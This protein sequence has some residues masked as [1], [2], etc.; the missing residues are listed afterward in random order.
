MKYE[1]TVFVTEPTRLTERGSQSY[2]K[3]MPD[4][5]EA[6]EIPSVN[7][8][9]PAEK[10]SNPDAVLAEMLKN[11]DK[12][13]EKVHKEAQNA[14]T[15]K[16]ETIKEEKKTD[17]PD[18]TSDKAS[19]A[20]LTK[21]PENEDSV[22]R[23]SV[24]S[25]LFEAF[26][27]VITDDKFIN[28][29][30]QFDKEAE[31]LNEEKL[32]A[33]KE[34]YQDWEPNTKNVFIK[35]VS[36][37]AQ[38]EILKEIKRRGVNQADFIKAAELDMAL[39]PIPPVESDSSSLQR[40]QI[41]DRFMTALAKEP[42]ETWTADVLAETIV[43]IRD[44]L[45]AAP[46][47]TEEDE[48]LVATLEDVIFQQA[49]ENGISESV[50]DEVIHQVEE[51]REVATPSSDV[52]VSAQQPVAHPEE[53]LPE[54]KETVTTPP[55]VVESTASD[56]EPHE[57]M[58]EA[59]QDT[60]VTQEV[61]SFIPET[62]YVPTPTMLSG[63]N[64]P[65]DAAALWEA[66]VR[67]TGKSLSP[68]QRSLAEQGYAPQLM[69]GAPKDDETRP[70]IFPLPPAAEVVSTHRTL[71][72]EER[73]EGT[74]QIREL[75]TPR[76]FEPT[77]MEAPRGRGRG[78]GGRGGQP[79]VSPEDRQQQLDEL[80][81]LE[82]DDY[83]DKA[84]EMRTRVDLM[85][86]DQLK[87]FLREPKPLLREAIR[88]A[89]RNKDEVEKQNIENQIN[90]EYERFR[91]QIENDLATGNLS[92]AL[93]NTHDLINMVE[94]TQLSVVET[95][96]QAALRNP[97]E[98]IY[99]PQSMHDIAKLIGEG[100]SEFATFGE[101]ELI[102]KDGNFIEE[103]FMY[104]VQ[105]KFLYFH[106]QDPDS[107]QPFFDLIQVENE[108][109]FRTVSINAML[110]N[111]DLYFKTNT[112][113]KLDDLFKYLTDFVWLVG[114]IRNAN[115]EYIQQMGSEAKIGDLL[116]SVMKSNVLTKRSAG[117]ENTLEAV[118]TLSSNFRD[119]GNIPRLISEINAM[120]GGRAFNKENIIISEEARKK[121]LGNDPTVSDYAERQARYAIV[122]RETEE[123]LT[124][125]D[126]L[127]QR[128]ENM[129]IG[130]GVAIGYL[131]YYN[132]SDFDYLNTKFG[133]KAKH[134]DQ[135][136]AKT[137]LFT[138]D[139]MEAVLRKLGNVNGKDSPAQIKAKMYDILFRGKLTGSLKADDPDG[140]DKW[141]KTWYYTAE[142]VRRNEDPE[143]T[144][145]RDPD[146]VEGVLKKSAR[147]DFIAM[148]NV[149]DPPQKNLN[150][151]DIANSLV[152]LVV[153]E[154][155]AKEKPRDLSGE[156]KKKAL[157]D[158]LSSSSTKF[159]QLLAS[160]MTFFTGA[161]AKNDVAVAATNA[162]AKPRHIDAYK[163]KQG[164]SSRAGGFGNLYNL[165]TIKQSYV[166]MMAGLL[167]VSKK[168]ILEIFEEKDTAVSKG[169]SFTEKEKI[170]RQL[171]FDAN[172]AKQYG[173]AGPP[174]Q[175][176]IFQQE[177]EG[178]E[179]DFHKFIHVDP[180]TGH[181]AYKPDA[182]LDAL[183]DAIIK[184]TRYAW[185]T[186]KVPFHKE[187]RMI[188]DRKKTPPEYRTGTQLEEM[189]TPQVLRVIEQTYISANKNDKKVTARYEVRPFLTKDGEVIR[190]KVNEEGK[191]VGKNNEIL[192]PSKDRKWYEKAIEDQNGKLD[193][194]MMRSWDETSFRRCVVKG[195]LL[196][197]FAGQL[198]GH[199]TT[200]SPYEY[201]SYG[202]REDVI[203]GLMKIPIDPEVHG[204]GFDGKHIGGSYFTKEDIK[205]LRNLSKNN[206]W[207]NGTWYGFIPYPGNV[208]LALMRDLRMGLFDGIKEFW[209]RFV[210]NVNIS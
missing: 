199:T 82:T 207:W 1:E 97:E 203:R 152:N 64:T 33:L 69:G 188:V 21:K 7:S 72:A 160:F 140:F 24:F 87:A 65:E 111:Q 46:E 56:E 102:D 74:D 93:K 89:T 98:E 29:A 156:A 153:A 178:K 109:L 92:D 25:K 206:L 149:F 146:V 139:G 208:P 80:V 198:Y 205:L 108:K 95:K 148:F 75:R 142:D 60:Q 165:G 179:V 166:D 150:Q 172:D 171:L 20:P 68:A 155:L 117:K 18:T 168:S 51:T 55:Q 112:G 78:G 76:G 133:E 42:A 5:V 190:Y 184:P 200:H 53:T 13:I 101:H 210:K 181:V 103:N 163:A 191:F 162:A 62:E 167:T 124:Y 194:N 175:V 54:V 91:A 118:A 17:S 15:Q 197:R 16:N 192:D 169:E 19:T 6:Q 120:P 204:E 47:K 125:M 2:A 164:E 157:D 27:G 9:T 48:Q 116:A 186:N 37:T 127:K 143:I 63:G 183:Q 88:F 161:A 119:W 39:S 144:K 129:D 151:S 193:P 81:K 114:S 34:K 201:M 176:K 182:M 10:K 26:S 71:D 100:S 36:L 12:A 170:A 4:H 137:S 107:S 49:A 83:K 131:I 113:E 141:A 189:F 173:V 132:M 115:T 28:K 73:E 180:V 45:A 41:V 84:D 67:N 177:I 195:Y 94:R 158:M 52:S 3:S 50:M 96:V 185:S 136:K 44:V 23:T 209:S 43:D 79:R 31:T 130:D 66:Y 32:E 40:E 61:H 121:I 126:R 85:D 154:R 77:Q 128:E 86:A 110:R 174:N 202:L 105:Q 30:K 8:A 187:V 90:S 57:T 99:S 104:W 106:D 147:K 14:Q 38:D 58:A 145:K 122:E 22:S 59:T 11:A 159:A 135:I 70:P 123:F 138:Q 196:N 35:L 134:N